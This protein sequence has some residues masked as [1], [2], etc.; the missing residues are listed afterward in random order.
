MGYASDKYGFDK[1]IK[2]GK[3]FHCLSLLAVSIHGLSVL[4][5]AFE[6]KRFKRW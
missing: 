2:L 3:V 5:F 1:V 6:E 4:F